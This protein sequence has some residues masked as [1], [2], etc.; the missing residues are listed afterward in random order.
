MS[1]ELPI[2][3]TNWSGPTAFMTPE[4]AYP[5][6]YDGLAPI[7]DGAFR[8]H[9]MAEPSVEHLRALM[10]RVVANPE[11]ARA[12]GKR[13]RQDMVR[14]FSADAMAEQASAELQRLWRERARRGEGRSGDDEL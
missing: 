3:A 9:L 13:A 12:K 14:E 10:R 5:L 8:G 7:P 6:R 11:E 4:N 1:M 2:I